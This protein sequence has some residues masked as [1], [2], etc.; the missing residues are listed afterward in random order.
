MDYDDALT[1]LRLPM[2]EL[3]KLCIDILYAEIAPL[4]ETPTCELGKT[5]LYDWLAEGDW[6]REENTAAE[7]VAQ[8][9][10]DL[11]EDGEEE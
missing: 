6:S 10:D 9:W 4:C 1:V 2:R 11:H 5:S 8:E 3:K 7:T